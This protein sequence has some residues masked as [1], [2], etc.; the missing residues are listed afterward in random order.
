MSIEFDELQKEAAVA[1]LMHEL[2]RRITPAWQ[3]CS[4]A[5]HVSP[6]SATY[7]PDNVFYNAFFSLL[8]LI[9]QCYLHSRKDNNHKS[10]KHKR[11]KE[12]KEK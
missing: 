4:E 7:P 12:K 9:R 6:K 11:I 10:Y 1:N 2:C 8:R 3:I 5:L